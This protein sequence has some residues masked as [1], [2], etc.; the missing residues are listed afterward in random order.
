M[1]VSQKWETCSQMTFIRPLLYIIRIHHQRRT[2]LER[3]RKN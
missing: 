3:E 1:V 2:D